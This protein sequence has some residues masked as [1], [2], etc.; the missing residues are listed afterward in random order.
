MMYFVMK[1]DVPAFWR[2]KRM[3]STDL[4]FVDIKP[5]SENGLELT[6]RIRNLDSGLVIIVLTG[7]DLPEYRKAASANGANYFF[8][9]D[10]SSVQEILSLVE[11]I[12]LG[13]EA[14][15]ESRGWAGH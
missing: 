14:S 15:L 13:L 2:T 7:Y 6:K 9:K 5:P 3:S 11:S 8:F 10:V 12:L 1:R 4:I